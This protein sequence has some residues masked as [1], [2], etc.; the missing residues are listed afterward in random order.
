VAN[1]IESLR[2]SDVDGAAVITDL[3][4]RQEEIP[5]IILLPP[6]LTA[7]EEL[8]ATTNCIGILLDGY[9]LAG[10]NLYNGRSQLVEWHNKAC[11]H[12]SYNLT[13]F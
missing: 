5:G 7:L 6:L 10:N 9:P 4:E 11:S 2:T 12:T 1:W 8:A 13:F 3:L